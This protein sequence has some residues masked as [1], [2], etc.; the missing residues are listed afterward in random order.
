MSQLITRH[1][2][3]LRVSFSKEASAMIV[4]ALEDAAL[5]G[6]VT[7]GDEQTLAVAAQT[8]LDGVAKLFERDRKLVKAPVL[9]YSKAIDGAVKQTIA[10]IEAELM[11]IAKLNAD[12]IQL[13]QAKERAALQAENERLL[14]LERERAAQIAKANSH[15]EVE[16]IQADFNDRAKAESLAVPT[17]EK[18][19]GL[20]ARPDWD[21]EVTNPG[22]LYSRHPQC[23]ELVPKLVEIKALLKAGVMVEGVKATPKIVTSIRQTATTERF[24]EV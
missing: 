17:V 23:V 11:R 12:Y 7:N 20:T 3:E 10:P 15:Q 14:A 2:A 9:E 19:K 24:I 22:L 4:Q 21:I 1:D 6:R 8:S 16:A 18:P 5:I 13:Q